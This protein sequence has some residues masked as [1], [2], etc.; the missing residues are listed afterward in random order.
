MQNTQYYDAFVNNNDDLDNL[1]NAINN[2]MKNKKNNTSTFETYSDSLYHGISNLSN[3][4]NSKFLPQNF[5]TNFKTY[6][7]K[8]EFT[9]QAPSIF[10]SEPDITS[11]VTTLLS[12]S[13]P[14]DE[15]DTYIKPKFTN[16]PIIKYN[17]KYSNPKHTYT[18]QSNKNDMI[19]HMH[20]QPYTNL[21]IPNNNN[22]QLIQTNQFNHLIQFNAQHIIIILLACIFIIIL[23]D[24]VCFSRKQ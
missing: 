1:A 5:N 15:S 2:K 17:T 4:S 8:S 12:S 18:K 23:I 7:D 22:N 14:P 21:N 16:K 10:S 9:S 13:S 20:T 6:S 19:E 24:M 3:S 11:T